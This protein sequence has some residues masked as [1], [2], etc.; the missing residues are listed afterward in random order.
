MVSGRASTGPGSAVGATW[1]SAARDGDGSVTSSANH[2]AGQVPASAPPVRDRCRGERKILRGPDPSTE[3]DG[4]ET[5]G[6]RRREELSQAAG[7]VVHG[8]VH[9]VIVGC[10]RVGS[11][12]AVRLVDQGHTVS[13][14]DKM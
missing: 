9:V 14:V 6:E 3:V 8:W 10:G 13:I 7:A 12:L 2:T 4:G 5:G 1:R 11:G